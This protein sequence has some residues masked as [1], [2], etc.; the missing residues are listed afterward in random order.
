MRPAPSPYITLRFCN[1]NQSSHHTSR[2]VTAVS[3]QLHA[4]TSLK[5]GVRFTT[6]GGLT[7][8][9]GP[10]A[11]KTVFMACACV[12]LGVDVDAAQPDILQAND[13]VEQLLFTCLNQT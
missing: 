11:I 6:G 10:E 3:C 13:V 7:V 8:D 5:S 9:T 4:G 12:K 2:I 1:N